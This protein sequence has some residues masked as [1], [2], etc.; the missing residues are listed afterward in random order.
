MVSLLVIV[1]TCQLGQAYRYGFC[2][3]DYVRG[4][5]TPHVYTR[6]Q[7][8]QGYPLMSVDNLVRLVHQNINFVN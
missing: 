5:R 8:M 6:T 4:M 1:R 3:Y 2:I 7:A